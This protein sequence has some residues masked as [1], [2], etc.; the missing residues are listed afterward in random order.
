MCEF[1]SQF[2]L[3]AIGLWCRAQGGTLDVALGTFAREE[4]VVK[5]LSEQRVAGQKSRCLQVGDPGS[6][7]C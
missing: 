5:L 6:K 7:H 4:Q 1:W 2:W 3:G